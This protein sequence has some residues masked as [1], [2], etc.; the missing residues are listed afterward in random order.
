MASGTQFASKRT[1]STKP[2]ALRSVPYARRDLSIQPP[3]RRP[4]QAQSAMSALGARIATEFPGSNKGWGVVVERYAD[5]LI[6]SDMRR[7]LLEVHG[8]LHGNAQRAI[9]VDVDAHHDVMRRRFGARRGDRLG[10]VQDEP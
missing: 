8:F 7:A 1:R 9:Q 2:P 5:M 4:R 3:T 6:G 10:L